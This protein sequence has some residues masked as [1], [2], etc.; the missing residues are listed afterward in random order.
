[1][2]GHANTVDDDGSK[3]T[4]DIFRPDVVDDDP[5]WE[6]SVGADKPTFVKLNLP[7]LWQQLITLVTATLWYK[8]NYNVR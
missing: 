8:R 6:N 5:V 2:D 4:V 3:S 7:I 1:M